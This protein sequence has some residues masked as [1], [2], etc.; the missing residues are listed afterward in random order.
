MSAPEYRTP[1]EEQAQAEHDA[2]VRA[3][4]D[5]AVHDGASLK[6]AMILGESPEVVER[7]VC[8]LWDGLR[9][10]LSDDRPNLGSLRLEDRLTAIVLLL[11]DR[12]T[13]EAIDILAGL[14][15]AGGA[16]C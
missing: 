7:W 9:D 10:A 5:K 14:R 6:V 13:A 8:T 3:V 12:V 16:P 1:E 4:L 11:D 2:R 15:K